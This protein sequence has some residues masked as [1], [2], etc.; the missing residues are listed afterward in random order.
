MNKI[1]TE[2]RYVL[3]VSNVPNIAELGVAGGRRTDWHFDG[4]RVRYME[5]SGFTISHSESTDTW[6]VISNDQSAKPKKKSI[7][8]SPQDAGKLDVLCKHKVSSNMRFV[9]LAGV[10]LLVEECTLTTS[11]KT[12]TIYST[13]SEDTIHDVAIHELLPTLG[14]KV[15][16]KYAGVPLL[17][18]MLL[19]S[20]LKSVD[21]IKLAV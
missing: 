10:E 1:R 13:E 9:T 19:T 18:V 3:D 17:T 21:D 11:G 7:T 14:I 2:T 6:T 5:T 12:T 15:G 4:W 20:D 16:T 8:M